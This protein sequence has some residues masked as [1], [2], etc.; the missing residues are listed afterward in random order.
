MWDLWWTKQL[1]GRLSPRTSVSL[2]I[3]STETGQ[4]VAYVPSGPVNTFFGT[5]LTI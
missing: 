1:W 2:D 3:H 5:L 4:I